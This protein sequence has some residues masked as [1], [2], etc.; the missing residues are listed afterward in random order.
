MC[1]PSSKRISVP[2]RESPHDLKR[3]ARLVL[4]LLKVCGQHCSD[5]AIHNCRYA[6]SSSAVTNVYSIRENCKNAMWQSQTNFSDGLK[7]PAS[8]CFG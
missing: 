6:A 7:L 2:M 3:I 4:S 5:A 1:L 8:H